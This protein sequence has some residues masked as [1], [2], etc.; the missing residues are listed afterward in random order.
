MQ[1]QIYDFMLSAGGSQQLAVVGSS[2]K[3]VDSTGPIELRTDTGVRVPLMPGQ[4]FRGIDFGSLTMIDKSAAQNSGKLLVISGEMTD[5]RIVGEVS[6][7]D[8]AKSRVLSS[9]SIFACVPFGY[10]PNVGWYS[11][12]IIFN[13]PTSLKFVLNQIVIQGVVNLRGESV[14]GC[15]I[16]K[17][18]VAADIVALEQIGTTLTAQGSKLAGDPALSGVTAYGGCSQ[19]KNPIGQNL[20]GQYYVSPTAAPV[21]LKLTEPIV[22]KA[23]RGIVICG[24]VPN[25]AFSVAVEGYWTNE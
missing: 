12:V 25:M 15:V 14:D 18:A 4:G 22:M 5:N 21:M 2:V 13:E 19:L 24:L 16:L 20:G 10:T 8:G 6:V 23:G 17:S 3:L 1:G 7:V 11:S 9:K